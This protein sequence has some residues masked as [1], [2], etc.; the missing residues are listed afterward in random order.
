MSAAAERLVGIQT[1]DHRQWTMVNRP[2]PWSRFAAGFKNI[3]F[4]F[5]YQENCWAKIEIHGKSEIDR[6]VL[7][8]AGA[9]VGQGTHTVMVQMAAEAVGVPFEKVKIIAS[10]SAT[11]EN[12]GSVSHPHD[13]HVWQCDSRR[14]GG[15]PEQVE[16]G[17]TPGHR[18]VQISG[19]AHHQLR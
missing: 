19:A 7:H 12:S 9:E 2:R 15:G 6:V 5:G 3:G 16:G 1:I 18:R 8:H 13:V 17:R 10:D 14:G 11:M 4:S